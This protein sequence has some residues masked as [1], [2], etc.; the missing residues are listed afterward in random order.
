MG[1]GKN[2]TIGRITSP[3][4]FYPFFTFA[5]ISSYA[6][7]TSRKTKPPLLS[8]EKTPGNNPKGAA[9]PAGEARRRRPTG[10]GRPPG[11][12][13]QFPSALTRTQ[14]RAPPV[15]AGRGRARPAPPLPAATPPRGPYPTAA[16]AASRPPALTLVEGLRELGAHVFLG[17]VAD[18]LQGHGHEERGVGGPGAA[19]PADRGGE[20]GR[21][22]RAQPGG[23]GGPS[24]A[25]DEPRAR[26][27]PQQRPRAPPH[28][29]PRAAE[30]A[31]ARG[32]RVMALR[33]P[34]RRACAAPPAPPPP[35]HRPPPGPTPTPRGRDGGERPRRERASPPSLCRLVRSFT[36]SLK[37]GALRLQRG[38]ANQHR[39]ARC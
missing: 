14:L 17:R 11:G 4:S 37:Q 16:A 34:R 29:Q 18:G 28:R 9:G 5:A 15:L 38:R 25:E 23:G 7:Q 39:R 12:S 2:L 27:E 19:V 30:A 31:A 6:G 20:G 35:R 26:R 13:R 21:G 3:D 8:R 22:G 36:G 32:S 33:P 10:L 1:L 24:M